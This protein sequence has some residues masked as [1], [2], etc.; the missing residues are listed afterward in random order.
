MNLMH[1]GARANQVMNDLQTPLARR[2]RVLLSRRLLRQS[3]LQRL[4][5]VLALLGLLAGCGDVQ[6]QAGAGNAFTLEARGSRYLALQDGVGAWQVLSGS[7]AEQALSTVALSDPRGRY[8]VMSVCLDEASG[9]L[10]VQLKHGVIPAVSRDVGGAAR[11]ESSVAA[12]HRATLPLVSLP[13]SAAAPP[14]TRVEVRA[15]VRGLLKGEYVGVY[16]DGASALVDASTPLPALELRS[17]GAA[18]LDIIATKYGPA[19]R[20]PSALL[21]A[22]ALELSRDGRTPV[23]LDFASPN[24]APLVAAQVPLEGMRPGELLSG[25]VELLMVSGT[26]ALL[27]EFTGEGV[28][29]YARPPEGLLRGAALRAEAQSFAYN[30]RTKAGSSLSVSHSFVEG[31]VTPLSLPPPLR[32]EPPALLGVATHLRPCATW[33]AQAANGDYTQFY[34]Q[35]REGHNV[36][37]R[38]TQ[39]FEYLRLL[40]PH[41]PTFSQTLPD[42]ST[43]PG[44]Q[45]AWNLVR[46]ADLFWDVSFSAV[47]GTDEVFGGD[48]VFS[49]RS[50]VIPAPPP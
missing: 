17:D 40:S 33:P 22:P 8:G 44:W 32:L 28:L 19:A 31:V 42:F 4:E 23:D 13:C 37:Y 48:S 29:S 30:D 41:A 9:A 26:R 35:V 27:G 43:L 45:P 20:L 11:P 2:S 39:S 6:T 15:Q 38:F 14:E 1:L 50:G 34:S 10:S 47:Q 36:S 12:T 49:S 7:P 5:A 21:L 16:M 18:K 46:G 3:L 25:S 24:A